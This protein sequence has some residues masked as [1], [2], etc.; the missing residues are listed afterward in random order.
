M[1]EI[2]LYNLDKVV[3]ITKKTVG[4]ISSVDCAEGDLLFPDL[5]RGL[6]PASDQDFLQEMNIKCFSWD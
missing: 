3:L 6:C 4:F 1:N 5:Q 2:S